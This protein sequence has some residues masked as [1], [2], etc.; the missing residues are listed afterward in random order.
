MRCTHR[1]PATLGWCSTPHPPGYVGDPRGPAW[2]LLYPGLDAGPGQPPELPGDGEGTSA[3]AQPARCPATWDIDYLVLCPCTSATPRETLACFAARRAAGVQESRPSRGAHLKTDY[4]AAGFGHVSRR[5]RD[6]AGASS[7]RPQAPAP[8]MKGAG[9]ARSGT[10]LFPTVPSTRV[11][12]ALRGTPPPCQRMA[13][14]YASV[15][16]R[17]S[18]GGRAATVVSLATTPSATLSAQLVALIV[19][20]AGAPSQLATP[21]RI[22]RRTRRKPAPTSRPES[23]VLR[24]PGAEVQTR[25]AS[26][27]C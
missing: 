6:P 22:L 2:D 20:P 4:A 23:R 10:M 16:S 3:T 9:P 1:A 26:T 14:W 24:R 8:P 25:G 7:R 12:P 21:A 11:T 19:D 27:G 17:S 15:E 5:H 13:A 18:P